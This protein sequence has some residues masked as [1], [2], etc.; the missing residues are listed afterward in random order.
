MAAAAAL[1]LLVA[2]ASA[3]ASVGDFAMAV[4]PDGKIVVAGGAGY[5]GGLKGREFAAVVRY[6]PGGKLDPGFG[7]G[8]GV[9]L[10]RPQNPFTAIA[11]QENGRILLTSAGGA[12]GV[13][14][15]LANGNLDR[16]FGSKGY[17]Y[18]GASS[19]WYPTSI[20]VDKSGSIFTAGM[21]GYPN[22]PGEAWYGWLYR[23]TA[24]GR[25]G[26]VT[27]GMTDGESGNPKTQIN[28]FVLAANETAI[29]AGT[30]AE[31][32]P[33]A[34]S[35]LSLARLT[36]DPFGGG[37][38]TE[39]DPNFGGG[40][41]QS[42]FFPD[43]PFPEA[44]NALTWSKGRLLVAGTAND[45]LLLARYSQQGILQPGFGH[46]GWITT[47]SSSGT[48]VANDLAVSRDGSVYVAGGTERGCEGCAGLLLARYGKRGRLQPGF[49]RR[50][51][52]TPDID[53]KRYG[54][55]AS[56]V[57][58]AVKVLAGGEVLV[59]GLVTSPGSS[60]YFLRRYLSDGAADGGFGRGGRLTTLPATA[61]RALP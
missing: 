36:E 14:R 9:V 3:P 20:A 48:D 17:L 58:Y 39:P 46:G 50:G 2:P 29:A 19:S 1:A 11:L 18:A 7:G 44:A 37:L 60:R 55:S 27:G 54:K 15:L 12:G 42:N 26:E 45:D 31:R 59:G 33:D 41:V 13:T 43:S 47:S 28:D 53:R 56:E 52:V 34:K 4:Q 35:H 51:T 49:G 61:Q 10:L 21:S 32:R 8:D 23:I 16:T 24:D 5:A 38:V 40:L 6:L 25:S 22:D 57:A 30:V